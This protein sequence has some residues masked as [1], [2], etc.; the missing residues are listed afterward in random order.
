MVSVEQMN[1]A[2]NSVKL[3]SLFS[4]LFSL[5]IFA[6]FISGVFESWIKEG[7]IYEKN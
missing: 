7:K 1:K 5:S 4:I 2:K 6:F 3:I